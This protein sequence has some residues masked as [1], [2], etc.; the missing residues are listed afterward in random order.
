MLNPKTSREASLSARGAYLRSQQN[1]VMSPYLREEDGKDSF[2][3]NVRL[4]VPMREKYQGILE[5]ANSLL[6]MSKN[7]NSA[8]PIDLN[9]TTPDL[10][11]DLAPENSLSRLSLNM[12]SD[13]PNTDGDPIEPTDGS[14]RRIDINPVTNSLSG[15]R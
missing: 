3:P 1:N 2:H 11:V 13:V 6:H 14:N 8:A 7:A 10:E 9:L 5:L 4:M 12:L 15:P